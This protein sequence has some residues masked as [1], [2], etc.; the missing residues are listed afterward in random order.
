MVVPAWS[1][2]NIALFISRKLVAIAEDLR[3]DSGLVVNLKIVSFILHFQKMHSYKIF[4][5]TLRFSDVVFEETVSK[6][7]YHP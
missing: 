5:E 6:E 7:C 2:D 4:P 3:E 1:P